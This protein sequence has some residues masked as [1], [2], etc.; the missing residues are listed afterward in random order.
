M[1]SIFLVLFLILA[2]PF[3][4]VFAQTADL[5]EEGGKEMPDERE[6]SGIE[7]P[8]APERIIPPTP[9]RKDR[10][11]DLERLKKLHEK[12]WQDEK[13][14]TGPTSPL[15]QQFTEEA[16]KK[17]PQLFYIQTSLA[18]PYVIASGQREKYTVE[19]GI[20]LSFAW[21][22]QK[23]IYTR[24]TY[25]GFRFASFSG[26]G[27]YDGTPGRYS[28]LYFGP[29]IG[30]G[31]VGKHT[32]VIEQESKKAVTAH[33]VKERSISYWETGWSLLAGIALQS[34]IGQ[35][36]PTSEAPGDDLN[37]TKTPKLDGIGLWGE[38]SYFFVFLGAL[39]V[40]LN[41]GV[42]EG[43]GKHFAWLGVGVSG[44]Y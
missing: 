28:F 10:E 39:G 13:H 2:L 33:E 7:L 30:F 27:V 16:T 44:W 26:S 40:N 32:E 24:H 5:A 6:G 21:K 3:S 20:H 38:A 34:R 42:Q 31:K 12:R 43:K 14:S 18:L 17:R 1:G 41:I 15:A 29:S 25:Y 4:H 23:D 19:P 37:T 36:D 22:G 8:P 11:Q 9:T 35:I